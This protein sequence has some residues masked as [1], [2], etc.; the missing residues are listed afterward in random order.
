MSGNNLY[1]CIFTAACLLAG[2]RP[3]KSDGIRFPWR[4]SP[5][6]VLH[7]GQFEILLDDTRSVPVDS[8]FLEGHYNNVRL[9]IDRI[10]KGKY[11]VVGAEIKQVIES[12]AFSVV[13]VKFDAGAGA[14]KK[15]S[16][17]GQ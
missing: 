2:V 5:A 7:G 4:A 15:I 1:I 11:S 12:G 10:D 9:T 6:I 13:D 17:H 8:I 16:I 14:V 3:A